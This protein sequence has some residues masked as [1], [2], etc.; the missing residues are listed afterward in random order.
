[1]WA[2]LHI[3]CGRFLCAGRRATFLFLFNPV[4]TVNAVCGE[5]THLWPSHRRGR[6]HAVFSFQ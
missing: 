4:Q 6:A 1:M 3:R 2:P 5:Q